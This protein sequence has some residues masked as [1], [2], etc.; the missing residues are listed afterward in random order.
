MYDRDELLR[1]IVNRVTGGITHYEYG[2]CAA[3]AYELTR[4]FLSNDIDDF[5]VREGWVDEGDQIPSAHTWIEMSDGREIDPSF[6]KVFGSEATKTADI[7]ATF[8]PREFLEYAEED[9]GLG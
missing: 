4:A 2:I 1:R 8:R 3:L 6:P 9:L 7:Q 5:V